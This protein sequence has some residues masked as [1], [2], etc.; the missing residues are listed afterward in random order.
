MA[1]PMAPRRAPTRPG[2]VFYLG[3]EAPTA[4]RWR[5]F[6]L[7]RT[8]RVPREAAVAFQRDKRSRLDSG[9]SLDSVSPPDGAGPHANASR[10]VVR[11]GYDGC[12]SL[13]LGCAGAWCHR[14]MARSLPVRQRLRVRHFHRGGA[15]LPRRPRDLHVARHPVRSAALLPHQ[16]PLRRW[17]ALKRNRQ[18]SVA[19]LCSCS[20]GPQDH[21]WT[22]DSTVRRKDRQ[23]DGRIQLGTRQLVSRRAGPVPR[24]AVDRPFPLR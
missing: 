6:L 3:R 21:S 5:L 16:H 2:P 10:P 9:R 8:A 17:M 12:C 4:E 1:P 14:V 19:F 23:G 11:A 20:G 7:P 15:D 13:S 24:G 22:C 18:L